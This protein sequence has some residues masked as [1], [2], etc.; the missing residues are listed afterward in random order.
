MA[1]L[2]KG[3]SNKTVSEN[4]SELRHAGKNRDQ[5]IAIALNEAGRSKKTKKTKK[6]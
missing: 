6:K 4:I 5:A 3:S 2:R 1:P